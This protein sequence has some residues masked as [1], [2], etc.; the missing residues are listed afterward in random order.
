M[1]PRLAGRVAIVT[2]SSSGLGRASALR[3]AKERSIVVCADLHPVS[4]A[5]AAYELQ[6]ATHDVINS[7]ESGIATYIKTDVRE[8]DQVRDLV[9]KTVT[10]YGRLDM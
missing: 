3:F 6:V 9:A 1:S 2:G 5:D 10:Q 8:E 7:E 4:K